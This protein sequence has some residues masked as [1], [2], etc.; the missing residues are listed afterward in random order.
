MVAIKNFAPVFLHD[1]F[2]D[3]K[4]NNKTYM[5]P[6]IF[7]PAHSNHDIGITDSVI[8][9]EKGDIGEK[10]IYDHLEELGDVGM[11][12]VNGFEL[13]HIGTWNEKIGIGKDRE[14][15]LP[16]LK[17][18]AQKELDFIIFHHQLG[19]ISLEV[20]NC[21]SESKDTLEKAVSKAL[22]QL[23]VS[24]TLIKESAKRMPIDEPATQ[25]T[26]YASTSAESKATDDFTI[27][28]KKVIALPSTKKN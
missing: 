7:R 20:K 6:P 17:L 22:E 9:S 16:E 2:P 11:F 15:A 13:Q 24:H 18:P 12:V 26:D 19:I 23:E 1:R 21:T 10:I 5:I 25:N 27:P 8:Y 3:W 14:Y 28:Y 4:V